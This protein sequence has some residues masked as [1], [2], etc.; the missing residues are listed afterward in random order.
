VV[1]TLGKNGDDFNYMTQNATMI[2]LRE[3]LTARLSRALARAGLPEDSA[4]ISP[5]T[6]H[7][8]GDY[9]SNA[10]MVLA[11]RLGENPR[12][13]AERILTCLDMAD[14]GTPPEV[15][16]A[17]FLNFRLSDDFLAK[18]IVRVSRDAR[19]GV[20]LPRRKKRIVI[21]FSCPNVAKPMH[22]GHIRSTILGDA[23][24][25]IAR[26]LGHDVITDNHIGDWGTQFGKV[27]Y[28]WKHFLDQDHLARKPVEELVRLYRETHRLES[29]DPVV[30]AQ[31]RKELVLLQ[32][33]NP[34][35]LNIWKQCIELSWKEFEK[36][37][38]ILD[39]HFDHC[40]GESFYNQAL[41]PLVERLLETKVAQ[42]SE[43]AVCIFFP[44][45]P[46]L[47]PCM[48]RKSDGGFLYAT[49]DLATLEYRIKS[50]NPDAIW[51]V[52]G[53]PQ[54]LHFRQIFAAARRLG[55]QADLVHIAF[56]SILGEDRKMM[57]TR[58]GE[59]IALADLLDEAIERATK[60]IAEKNST[61]SPEEQKSIAHA[62]GIGAVKYTELSQ[63]RLTDYVFSWDKMLSFQGNTAPYLQNAYVR[64]RSIFRKS[65]VIPTA[66]TFPILLALPEE[67]AL[68]LKL[69]Q[70]GETVPA[71]L[72]EFRPN[73]L[74]N[75]LFE[76]A[77]SFHSFY[78]KCP[79]LRA[80]DR[81]RKSRFAL[82]N[83]TAQ[84]LF[85]GLSLLGI[86]PP[87][88]M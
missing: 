15:A 38:K 80:E 24:V 37:Y 62:I 10:A 29:E 53:S 11:K 68:A 59:N 32:Q 84:I 31:A 39:I 78:E 86:H 63:N 52:T 40:L 25:R 45:I 42:I 77:N 13:I 83:L 61:L 50:W 87:E 46:E 70:F 30:A 72:E 3:E 60:I 75:Y 1:E 66:A 4:E 57:K 47:T 9:Q 28:G 21:D 65:D 14:L 6:T 82:C 19:L 79:V 17:G 74:A 8:F 41:N 26:F 18:Q 34:E 27:I 5:T 54:A 12:T 81:I 71:V 44:E 64:I 33:G 7:K 16:G 23:L 73:L 76:L 36:I 88:R 51:Y 55:I 22:V 58:S 85:Q 48:I 20:P 67:R 56:G 49:T 43:G 69:L 2:T 35:N